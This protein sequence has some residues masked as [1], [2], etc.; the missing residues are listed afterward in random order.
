MHY[1]CKTKG[2]RETEKRETGGDG[3]RGSTTLT[4]TRREGPGTREK[5]GYVKETRD[6]E[7]ELNG[8]IKS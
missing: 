6:R 7:G 3:C 1:L 8:E 4:S 2:G 5:N